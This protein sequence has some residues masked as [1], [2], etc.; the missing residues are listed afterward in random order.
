M[1]Q[2]IRYQQSKN[3]LMGMSDIFFKFFISFGGVLCYF[4]FLL[5]ETISLMLHVIHRLFF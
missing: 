5:A 2:G 3:D 4:H 1:R